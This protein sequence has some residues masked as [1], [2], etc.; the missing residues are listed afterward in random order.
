MVIVEGIVN[1]A[2]I[3]AAAHQMELSQPAKLVR[4]SRLRHSKLRSNIPDIQFPFEQDGD[5]PQTGWVAEGA[6][7]VS[8][9]GESIFLGQHN[10]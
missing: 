8:K 3:L 10:I 1:Q 9:M 6:E 2:A 7:Q 5:D 4:N